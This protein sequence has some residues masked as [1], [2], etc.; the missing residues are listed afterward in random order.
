MTVFVNL[1]ISMKQRRLWKLGFWLLM[2]PAVLMNWDWLQTKA[3][4]CMYHFEVN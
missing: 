3:V 2:V 4:H 1:S